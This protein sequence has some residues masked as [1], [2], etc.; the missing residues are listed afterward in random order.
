LRTIAYLAHAPLVRELGLS[1]ALRQL[2]GGFGRRTG[3]NIAMDL[4]DEL[5][6]APAAEAA[7]YRIV[8]EALS[9]VHRHARATD[10]TVMLAQR[11][12]VLHV[13]VADNGT[14]MPSKV[15][16]G[17]GLS[18]MRDR[19]AELGGRLTISPSTTG[20]VLI[21]SLPGI[22]ETIHAGPVAA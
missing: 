5:T 10:V 3:L 22:A 16:R 20:T 2:A 18:S 6:L 21:A 1:L 13:V 17:V 19:I 8:Q 9:N 11:R 7:V 12:S 4:T 15:K 14:G